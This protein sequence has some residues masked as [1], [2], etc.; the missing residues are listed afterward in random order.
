MN[1][2]ESTQLV[3]LLSRAG[4]LQPLEGQA[5]VWAIALDDVRAVDALTAAR[6]MIRERLGAQ[7]W[8]TP[9]DVRHAVRRLRGRRLADARCIEGEIPPTVLDDQPERALAWVREYRHQIADG[10][11]PAE[12]DA[13]A[14]H[15]LDV[16]SER[17]IGGTRVMP[18]VGSLVRRPPVRDTPMSERA[19]PGDDVPDREEFLASVAAQGIVVESEPDTAHMA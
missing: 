12:A 15:V 19:I 1:R 8:V 16:E 10:A 2:M 18:Q 3:T 13:R 11:T 14:C 4:L 7:R 6:D 9:G 5:D 17:R